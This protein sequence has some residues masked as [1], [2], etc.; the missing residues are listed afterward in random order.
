M[1]DIIYDF[2]KRCFNNDKYKERIDSINIW[3]DETQKIEGKSKFL[4]ENNSDK[5]LYNV[6]FFARSNHQIYFN[7][8]EKKFSKVFPGYTEV[9]GYYDFFPPKDKRVELRFNPRAAGQEHLVPEMC[10]TDY[11]GKFWYLQ[12]NGKLH[13]IS[14]YMKMLQDDGKAIKHF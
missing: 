2:S 8:K 6:Y 13:K 3:L 11:K 1:I 5:C 14:D 10:F 9:L 4:A 12:A 7:K